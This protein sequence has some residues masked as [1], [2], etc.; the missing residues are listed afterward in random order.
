[1]QVSKVVLTI[2]ERS[3]WIE[4]PIVPNTAHVEQALTASRWLCSI[5]PPRFVP[6]RRKD[7]SGVRVRYKSHRIQVRVSHNGPAYLGEEFPLA[8]D[9]TNGDDRELDVSIDV[10]LQPTEIDEAGMCHFVSL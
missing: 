5:E 3:W 8:I 10:L 1:M 9:V 6:I 4:V 2:K 7:H